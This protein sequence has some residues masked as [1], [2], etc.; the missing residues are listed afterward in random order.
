MC[1]THTYSTTYGNIDSDSSHFSVNGGI[2]VPTYLGTEGTHGS[3]SNQFLLITC[4]Y[5][6]YT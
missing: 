1:M 4:N 5:L 2:P 3:T 6:P